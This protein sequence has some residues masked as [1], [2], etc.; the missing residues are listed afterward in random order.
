MA[1]ADGCHEPGTHPPI[2][3]HTP[4]DTATGDRGVGDRGGALLRHII[5]HIE[6]AK[7]ATGGELVVHEPKAGEANSSDE[8]AFGTFAKP[9]PQVRIVRP[10]GMVAHRR[11]V[12]PDQVT[13]PFS[14]KSRCDF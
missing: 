13:R 3:G 11:S 7:P 8:R 4:R 9:R 5:N 10:P 6:D 2:V 14:R 12:R 1:E